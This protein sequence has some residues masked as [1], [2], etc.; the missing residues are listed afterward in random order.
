MKI[1]NTLLNY[2]ENVVRTAK[3]VGIN[4]IIIE[5][6]RVRGIDD[7]STIVLFQTENVP[8]LDTGSIGL[9][10]IDVFL[11]RFDIAKSRD[12]FSVE[13]VQDKGKEFVRAFMMKGKNMKVDY[14]CANPTTIRAPKMI[15]DALVANIPLDNDTV[16]LIEKGVSA[17][18][19]E[20]VSIISDNRGVSFEIEDLNKDRLENTWSEEIDTKFTHKYPAKTLITLFKQVPETSFEIGQKG[21]LRI[22]VNELSIYVLPKG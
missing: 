7:L 11:S 17:M 12:N 22:I 10:R 8:E 5:P 2:I 13:V 9:N 6:G 18:N 21:I 14:R 19:A 3:L 16:R 15:H 20:L 4:S 1:D